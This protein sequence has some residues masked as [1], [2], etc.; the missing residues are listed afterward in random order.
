MLDIR[1]YANFDIALT[2]HVFRRKYIV[3]IQNTSIV[4]NTNILYMQ[5]RMHRLFFEWIYKRNLKIDTIFIHDRF[6]WILQ[7]KFNKL[8]SNPNTIQKISKSI[9]QFMEGA[10][11]YGTYYKPHYCDYLYYCKE[12][13]IDK[14]AIDLISRF[15]RNIRYIDLTDCHDIDGTDFR[16]LEHC[17]K[18][19]KIKINCINISEEDIIYLLQRLKN[20]LIFTCDD[21]SI[22]VEEN[23]KFLNISDNL[24]FEISKLRLKKITLLNCINITDSG[25]GHL[26]KCSSLEQIKLQEMS[27][28]TSNGILTLLDNK[29][30]LSLKIANIIIQTTNI[31]NLE[32]INKV[33][34]H[35]KLIKFNLFQNYHLPIEL[36]RLDRLDLPILHSPISK[37]IDININGKI[38]KCNIE[39][40]L[41]DYPSLN[42]DL[43]DDE[44]IEEEIDEE[45][46]EEFDEDLI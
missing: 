32:I 1:E 33:L 18:L 29:N 10:F 36:D 37:K 7:Y 24:L 43:I 20:L 5:D 40:F 14:T 34:R 8:I 25:L 13:I 19:E 12:S 28:I 9:P 4:F 44:Y 42:E 46:D 15:Q 41:L 16:K 2:N 22:D 21:Y 3:W 45:F 39:K 23:E 31:L 38:F 6:Q 35:E 17:T 30:I 26:S 11:N 27:N